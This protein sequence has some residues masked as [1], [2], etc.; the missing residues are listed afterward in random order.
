[1]L[2][3]SRERLQQARGQD[4]MLRPADEGGLAH[5]SI[6]SSDSQGHEL[7]KR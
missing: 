3:T 6:Y 2:R 4:V 5:A 1:M 7:M